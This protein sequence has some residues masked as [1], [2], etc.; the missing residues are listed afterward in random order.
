MSENAR[1]LSPKQQQAVMALLTEPSITAAAAKVRVNEKTIR[2]WLNDPDF[3]RAVTAAEAEALDQATRRLVGLQ[4][5]AVDRLGSLLGKLDTTP[6]AALETIRELLAD[7][8][9]APANV[10][11]RIRTAVLGPGT[12]PALQLRASTAVLDYTMRLLELRSI[13]Q[14]LA[15]LETATWPR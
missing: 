5:A 2:R 14:R 1:T 6:A 12:T 4:D 7:E 13:E 9:T 8:E 15:A 11:A 3:R 10:L